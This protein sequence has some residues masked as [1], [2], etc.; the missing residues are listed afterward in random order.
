MKK[1]IPFF[2]AGMMEELSY[3]AAIYSWVAISV[4]QLA[5]VLFLWSAVYANATDSVI[6]GF[7]FEQMIVYFVF[8]N[9]FV[10]VCL[11]SSTLGMIDDEIKD[12]TIAI[13]FIKPISYR[14]RFLAT[15]YGANMTRA[16]ILG[17]PAYI[18]AFVIF[19]FMGYVTLGTPV[20]FL[21]RILLF[22]V[23][24]IL[25]I[26]LN[27][28]INYICGILCFYT[29]AAWGLNQTKN[30]VINFFSGVFIPL[31]FFP[32][33]FGN[34]CRLLPFAGLTQ[35]PV[36]ILMGAA[37]ME[38]SVQFVLRNLIWW[39]VFEIVAKLLFQH[40]SKRVTVQGG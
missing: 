28:C 29:T 20:E 38:Q 19:S 15:A 14:L 1:Y 25:A 37:N 6:N 18:I 33:L 22:L 21:G 27:D 8:T 5:C 40:A 39:I 10:F 35:N 30:V 32:G 31:T 12:G 26:A 23:C 34:I 13:S 11:E 36:Y 7:T 16:I 24:T 9:I 3:K 17:I 2:K 4:L